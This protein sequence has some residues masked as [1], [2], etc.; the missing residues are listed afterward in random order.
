MK[1]HILLFAACIAAGA[2]AYDATIVALAR[3][4]QR[5]EVE[6]QRQAETPGL[7]GQ[8]STEGGSGATGEAVKAGFTQEPGTVEVERVI[9]SDPIRVEHVRRKTL[10]ARGSR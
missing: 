7:P 8:W 5:Y 2:L 6:Q 3:S 1:F 10:P 9:F 4:D